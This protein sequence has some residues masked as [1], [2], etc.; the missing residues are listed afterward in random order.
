MKTKKTLVI[1]ASEKTE[2]YANKAVRMLQ[3]HDVPVLA[4]G[5]KAGQINDTKI[6]TEFPSDQ[7]I[8]SISLYLSAKNQNEYYDSII[9]LKPKRVIFN[10]GTENPAFEARLQEN[11]IKPEVACTLVL[12]ST[13]VY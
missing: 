10:P 5:N 3:D 12:L 11:G 8:H 13:G 4:F 1:G 7:D 2:R 9:E 6:S